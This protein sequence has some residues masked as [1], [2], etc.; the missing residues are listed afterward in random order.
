[1]KLYYML[2]DAERFHQR[3]APALG[4]SWRRRSFDPCRTLCTDLLPAVKAFA[5]RYHMTFEDSLLHQFQASLPFDRATWRA[6][7]SEILLYS[8]AEVPELPNIFATLKCVLAGMP[9]VNADR[10]DFTP[11]EQIELGSRDLM[12]GGGYYRP[13]QAGLN[14]RD[15]V[16]RLANYLNSLQPEMWTASALEGLSELPLNEEREEELEFVR[17]EFPTLERIYHGAR[18]SGQVIICEKF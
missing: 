4:A 6:L 18:L 5:E 2:I 15:D 10:L 1:M 9:T 7:V 8:A 16:A 13:E 14:D 11:F 17:Q 3:L 12:F